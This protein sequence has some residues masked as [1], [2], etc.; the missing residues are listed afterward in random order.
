[1][2]TTCSTCRGTGKFGTFTTFDSKGKPVSKTKAPCP[3]CTK[4]AS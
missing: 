1:M 3:D 4:A 2:K